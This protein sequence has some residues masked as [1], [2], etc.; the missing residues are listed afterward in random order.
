MYFRGYV[1]WLLM[2]GLFPALE[3]STLQAD[4]IFKLEGRNTEIGFVGTKK[5]EK[6]EGG[7]RMLKG[8]ITTTNS[9][10]L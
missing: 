9:D 7:F 3:L 2:L 6:H 10:P 4:E 8:T 1:V 5:D